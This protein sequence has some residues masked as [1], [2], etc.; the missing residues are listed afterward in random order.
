MLRAAAHAHTQ[1]PCELKPTSLQFHD[2]TNH[3]KPKAKLEKAIES[4]ALK[5]QTK[6]TEIVLAVISTPVHEVEP[7]D[8]LIGFSTIGRDAAILRACIMV[9]GMLEDAL[10]A[11]ELLHTVQG[12]MRQIDDPAFES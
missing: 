11:G 7:E 6:T 1:A 12:F 2:G 4:S 3:A 10:P 8:Q 9:S 5:N